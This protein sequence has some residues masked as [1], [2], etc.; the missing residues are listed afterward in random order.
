VEQC[1]PDI[2]RE[3]WEE[4]VVWSQNAYV[5]TFMFH[6]M[7]DLDALRQFGHRLDNR[8]EHGVSPE[9]LEWIWGQVEQVE[10]RGKRYSNRFRAQFREV[11][12]RAKK[13][14]LERNASGTR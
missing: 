8:L 11:L 4:A 5:E 3:C 9:L 7:A 1:P 2:N 6:D 13:S 12:E 14:Q 10:P